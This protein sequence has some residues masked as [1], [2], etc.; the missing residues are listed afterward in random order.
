MFIATVEGHMDVLRLLVEKVPNDLEK[1]ENE[2]RTPFWAACA[3]Q[4]L[5]VMS[6]L[7]KHQANLDACDNKG[8]SPLAFA[9]QQGHFEVVKYL[10]GW[11][12]DPNAVSPQTGAS[13]RDWAEAQ[14]NEDILEFFSRNRNLSEVGGAL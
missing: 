14:G 8:L 10:V 11:G 12:V 7:M 2:G 3:T 9:A 1:H 5:N 4:Q 6:F 13:A